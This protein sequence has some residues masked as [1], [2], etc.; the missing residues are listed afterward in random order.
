MPAIIRTGTVCCTSTPCGSAG[1]RVVTGIHMMS[2]NETSN[3]LIAEPDVDTRVLYQYFLKDLGAITAVESAAELLSAIHQEPPTLIVTELR[4]PDVSGADLCRQIRQQSP[5]VPIVAVTASVHLI[6]GAVRAGCDV[7]ILKPALPQAIELRIRSALARAHAQAARERSRLALVKAAQ[8][9][10]RSEALTD[11]G[12]RTWPTVLCPQCHYAGVVG[13][14][15]TDDGR[16]LY[17]C[18]AC[19]QVWF[20][21]RKAP[22]GHS[23]AP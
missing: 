12:M 4:L 11:H 6:P 16:W 2:G 5:T 21:G 8:L 10:R 13:V 15:R 7:V 18:T 17:A 9:T 14:D 22:S 20:G 23:T 19:E 1:T 3:L